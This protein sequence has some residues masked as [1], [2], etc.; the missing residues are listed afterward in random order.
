MGPQETSDN[1]MIIISSSADVDY[2]KL[3]AQHYFDNKNSEDA[4]DT[5]GK[6]YFSTIDENLLAKKLGDV[7]N[8]ENVDFSNDNGLIPHNSDKN[9]SKMMLSARFGKLFITKDNNNIFD[10]AG[11]KFTCE[12]L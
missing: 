2:S 5:Q 8:C 11:V 1:T 6:Q 9:S 3:S 7:R 10:D 4:K 12:K